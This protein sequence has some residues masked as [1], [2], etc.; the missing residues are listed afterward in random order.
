MPYTNVDTLRS[1]FTELII[2]TGI[3]KAF[4]DFDIQN[5][6]QI[7]HNYHVAAVPANAKALCDNLI[8]LIEFMLQDDADLLN[9]LDL[10][11]L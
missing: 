11:K 6:H 10:T 7:I 1:K 3:R 9:S 2:D 4:E 5:T 8:V